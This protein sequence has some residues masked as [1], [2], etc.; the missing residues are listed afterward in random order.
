MS[1][2]KNPSHKK[3]HPCT[4]SVIGEVIIQPIC[5]FTKLLLFYLFSSAQERYSVTYLL[6]HIPQRKNHTHNF[7][8]TSCCSCLHSSNT[9]RFYN[10][11]QQRFFYNFRLVTFQSDNRVFVPLSVRTYRMLIIPFIKVSVF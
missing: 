5:L 7:R 1:N 6:F 4:W 8:L 2:D 11:F 9:H 10:V 3:T